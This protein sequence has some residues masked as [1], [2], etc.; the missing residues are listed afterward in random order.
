[1]PDYTF[2]LIGETVYIRP[3]DAFSA[4]FKTP[5]KVSKIDEIR[6]KTETYGTAKKLAGRWDI[7]AIENDWRGMLIERGG[8][9]PDKPDGSFIAYVKWYVKRDSLKK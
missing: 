2:E 6:L 5:E 7:Y 1:M 8:A 9:V 4:K 3:K